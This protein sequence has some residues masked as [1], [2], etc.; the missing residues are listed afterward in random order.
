MDSVPIDFDKYSIKNCGCS[1]DCTN[2]VGSYKFS[3]PDAEQSLADDKQTCWGNFKQSNS[4]TNKNKLQ[5]PDCWQVRLFKNRFPK[6]NWTL[7]SL[8]K[9]FPLLGSD[10]TSRLVLLRSAPS[11]EFFEETVWFLSVLIR[12]PSYC[13]WLTVRTFSLRDPIENGGFSI[14]LKWKVN[15]IT[16]VFPGFLRDY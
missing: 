5:L 6:V 11:K 3:C 14:L 8:F 10:C 1:H 2:I 13:N 15:L 7:I 12:I 9:Y 4:Q 16:S